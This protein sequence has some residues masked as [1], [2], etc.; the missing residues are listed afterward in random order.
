MKSTSAFAFALLIWL[1]CPLDDIYNINFQEIDGNTVDLSQYKGK[2][3]MI[4]VLPVSTDSIVSPSELSDLEQ[5]FDSNLL[6]IGVPAIEFG[7]NSSLRDQVKTVYNEQQENFILAYGMKVKKS[8]GNDQSNLFQWLTNNSRNKHF[9]NDIIGVGH[10]FF[11]NESG[12]LYAELGP[13][14]K[15]SSQIVNRVLLTK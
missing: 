15:V 13:Q 1:F 7:Y 2:K 6:V 5:Q 8:A 9:D 11:I 12:T 3:M 4:I 10:K 14:T